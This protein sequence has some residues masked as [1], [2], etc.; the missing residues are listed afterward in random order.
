MGK[1][2]R[3][4]GASFER[5]IVS[6]LATTLGVVTRRNLTQYQVS[7]EG[8]LIVGDYVIECKRRRKIAVYEFME[9]AEDACSGKQTPIVVMRADGKKTLAMMRWDDFMKLLGN[10]L[11]PAQPEVHPSAKDGD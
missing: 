5:E 3:Q 1:L 8:D 7:N 2:Q 9:Q 4:R 11:T 6:D 10:E